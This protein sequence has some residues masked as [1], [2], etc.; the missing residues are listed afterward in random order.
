MTGVVWRVLPG[1]CYV[2]PIV[3]R[4]AGRHRS[5]VPI[6]E[7]MLLV[8]GAVR[9]GGMKRVNSGMRVIGQVP[10]TMFSEIEKAFA[11]EVRAT[12][13]EVKYGVSTPSRFDRPVRM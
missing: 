3:N 4:G 11:A 1:G 6:D 5:D 13:N 12:R 9:P 8:R 7:R 2:F 10:E